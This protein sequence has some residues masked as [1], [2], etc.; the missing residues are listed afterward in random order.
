VSAPRTAV[1]SAASAGGVRSA[2]LQVLPASTPFPPDSLLMNGSFEQPQLTTP[3]LITDLPGW[4]ITQGS[5]DVVLGWQQAPGQG[6][7]SLDLVG[8]G[9]DRQH[10]A[11]AIEQTVPTVPG[12]E[13][14]LSGWMAHNPANP[15][16][17]EGRAN[18]LLNGQF[19][20]QLF[21]RDARA[22]ESNM[23]WV[24]FAYQFHASGSATML[25]ISDVT[26]TWDKG[27]LALD[28]LAITPVVPNLLVNGSFE[29]PD[30]SAVLDGFRNVDSSGLPGWRVPQGTVA[31]V[32]RRSWQPAPGQGDQVLHLLGQQGAG[33]VIE[34]SIATEP[35][36][37][38]MLSG[39]VAHHPAIDEGRVNI[40]VNGDLLTQ[41]YHSSALYGP[42]TPLELRWQPFLYRFRAMAATTTLQFV[43]VTGHSAVEGAALDGL[44]VAP[45]E[46]PTL[47]GP[48]PTAPSALTVRL[49]S[50]SQVDLSWTDTS[51][52]ETMFEI[53]RRAG[54][55]DWARIALVASGVTR[56]SDYGV[57][58]N[59]T[60]AYRVRA[61]ND[62]GAS[63]W[64][65]VAGVTTL[66]GV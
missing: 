14:L 59:A 38:Y 2:L 33:G 23:R 42:V 4:R 18:V 12:K 66:P 21:H 25:S 31:V 1:L 58:P 39:W 27:G 54:D 62:S 61:L 26:G 3:Q 41:L 19:F 43:D 50:P 47:G 7:Q 6:R 28:G 57:L 64:S 30:L 40:Y 32:D 52:D 34:Q 5:V 65:N 13:Y 45:V 24:P 53:Q 46:E 35:G 8:D 11:G 55:G 51:G 29:E 17:P 15:V 37:L 49:V 36:R 44:I 9:G 48:P 63:D 20:V 56:F 10:P 60:Y 22:T 16:A